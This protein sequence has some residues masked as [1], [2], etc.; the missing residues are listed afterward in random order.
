MT[1]FIRVVLTWLLFMSATAGM[2]TISVAVAQTND[3]T[4]PAQQDSTAEES[5]A[6]ETED[7]PPLLEELSTPKAEELLKVRP[8]DWMVLKNGRVIIVEPIKPRP[9]RL[10]WIEALLFNHNDIKKK[11]EERDAGDDDQE[12]FDLAKWREKRLTYEYFDIVLYDETGEAEETEFRIQR[13]YVEKFIHFEDH[14]LNETSRLTKAG[15][16]RTAYELLVFLTR[17]DTQRIKDAKKTLPK[18]AVDEEKPFPWDKPW[19][20]LEIARNDLLLADV[21]TLRKAGRY[22]EAFLRIEDLHQSDAV[23]PGL[24]RL[25]GLVANEFIARVDTAGDFRQARFFID[26][27]DKLYPGHRIS[28]KWKSQYRQ[29]AE[30][31]RT[32]GLK[33]FSGADY[34]AGATKLNDAYRVWPTL[35]GLAVEYRRVATRYQVLRSG[36]LSLPNGG[37]NEPHGSYPFEQTSSWRR[38]KLVSRP[39]LHVSYYRDG[40]PRYRSSYL[41]DWVPRDLGREL[42]FLLRNERDSWESRPIITTADVLQAFMPALK[43]GEAFDERLELFINEIRPLS[44]TEFAITLA[45]VPARPE[46]LFRVDLAKP[47][48][49][50][51]ESDEQH[52]GSFASF[53]GERVGNDH[54]VYTRLFPE[55]EQL[56]EYHVAEIQERRYRS[57]NEMIRGFNRNEVDYLPRIQV[58]DVKKFREDERVFVQP[59][60]L[61]ASH[62]LQFRPDSPYF[63]LPA[64]RRA[65]RYAMDRQSLLEKEFLGVDDLTSEAER[66]A[67]RR[68][69]LGRVVTAPFASTLLGYNALVR[70]TRYEIGTATALVFVD[71]ERIQ[72]IGRPLKLVCPNDVVFLRAAGKIVESWQRVGLNAELVIAN[73]KKAESKLETQETVEWDVAYRVHRLEDPVYDFVSLL[74]MK[75]NPSSEDLRYLPSWIVRELQKLELVSDIQESQEQLRRVHEIVA[76]EAILISLWELDEFAVFRRNIRGFPQQLV[77]PYDGIDTWVIQPNLAAGEF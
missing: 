72:E 33:K 55:P 24:S 15:D 2:G 26:R 8:F 50:D 27:L 73:P 4:R 76:K 56:L 65:M 5:S 57:Y 41:E 19:P 42:R 64:V 6:G 22:E 51:D 68:A 34:S 31:L 70:S 63:K 77:H 44:P 71:R 62:F 59:Y 40:S 29:R 53:R 25:A 61:P 21:A 36:V 14:L 54:L 20:G 35:P 3:E 37:A 46:A 23:V 16:L 9:N 7:Q 18:I 47:S 58:P 45:R 69:N 75:P 11:G 49:P 13:K 17:R 60:A 66:N 74:A 30:T 39:L 1:S 38:R 67:I 43:S 48:D 52:R 32:E 28:E 10:E 12:P